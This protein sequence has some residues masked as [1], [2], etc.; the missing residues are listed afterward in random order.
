MKQILRAF[1]L[2][3]CGFV[4]LVGSSIAQDKPA[5][6]A[7]GEW[8]APWLV[9]VKDQARPLLLRV[10]QVI[11]KDDRTDDLDAAFNLETAVD[12]FSTLKTRMN[13]SFASL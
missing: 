7:P 4:L 8:V 1:G 5:E 3:L 10:N 2:M 13:T 11:Q 12:C 6:A 9:T